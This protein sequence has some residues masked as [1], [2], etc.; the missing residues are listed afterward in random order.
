VRLAPPALAPLLGTDH[1]EAVSALSALLT[2]AAGAP[3][4]AAEQDTVMPV[5]AGAETVLDA[6]STTT[7][8]LTPSVPPVP[9]QTRRRAA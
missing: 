4:D 1:R 3:S 5:P 8:I 7:V 2:D 6:L 9:R